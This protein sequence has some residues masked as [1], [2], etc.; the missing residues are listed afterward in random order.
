MKLKALGY[1][2]SDL[3]TNLDEKSWKW[4]SFVLKSQKLTDRSKSFSTIMNCAVF[5]FTG[6][7]IQFLKESNLTWKR[8]FGYEERKWK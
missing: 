4:N 5:K 7:Y 2:G 3:S 6:I 8:S 1:E